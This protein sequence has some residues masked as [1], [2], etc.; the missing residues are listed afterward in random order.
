MSATA[1][2]DQLPSRAALRGARRVVIKV[3]TAMVA[4]SDGSPSLMRIGAMVEQIA[5]LIRSGKEVIFVSS[6]AVGM[7][8][9]L[10]RR[11]TRMTMSFTDL[12]HS[13]EHG[14]NGTNNN[15]LRDSHQMIIERRSIS[16]M[17]NKNNNKN[18][19]SFACLLEATKM[20]DKKSTEKQYDSACAAAGQLE[21]M[22]FYNSLFSQMELATSQILVTQAD[23]QDEL[24]LKNLTYAIDRLL[25]VGVIPIINE[26]D[27]VSANMGYTH[28]DT[29]S[30]NDSLA[31]LCARNF[32][33]EVLLLL[34][35]VQGVYD[36]PPSDEG[37]QLL[38]LYTDGADVAIG[39]KSTQGRGGMAAKINAAKSAVK[40]GSTCSACII[41]GGD[42]LDTI[43][44]VLY[45]VYDKKPPRG[46]LFATPDTDLHKQALLEFEAA[47]LASAT[48]VSDEARAM[49]TAA[50]NEA[51]KLQ[52]LPYTERQ[53]ILNA[54]AEA[55]ITNK[56]NLLKANAID[57]DAADKDGTALPLVKRLK[58]TDEKLA[59]L[60]SGIRQ[61]AQQKDPL[62]VVKSKRELA[63]GLELSQITVPIGVLMIIFESRPDSMPQISALALASGNGLLLKGGKEASRSNVALHKVIGEAIES[64]SGG[65][66]SKDI[67]GLVTSRG[68]VADMLN[69]DEVID[70]VIPRGSNALVSFIKANTK[71][72]VLGHADGVCHVYVAPSANSNAASKMVVDSKT[73]YPS[74][75]N[76]MESLLL[77]KDTIENGV[78][79]ATMMNLRAAGVKCFGGLNAMKYGLCDTVAKEL[80]FEYGDLR[81]LVEVVENVDE[82]IQWIHKY[83]SGHT[84]AIV[85][86]DED[87]EGEYFLK[88]VDAACVFK[89]ASTRFA[90]GYRFGLGAEVGISTGRIHARGPVGVEGLLTT[91]WQLRSKG[92]NYVAEFV[93]DTLESKEYTHR[94]LL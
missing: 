47:K 3:G 12:H 39:E 77:H 19:S 21:L 71:I 6:G 66:I 74:A 83:G 63:D 72:P 89:N 38:S 24:R 40:P 91:K 45:P 42:D 37:A 90:D 9:R 68:Q 35:D 79:M 60:A 15:N 1:N 87:P 29:F 13:Q 44:S 50:R 32:G 67:I 2:G 33:A 76:A 26:N 10:L 5:E 80:K 84:E 52:A 43:H 59:T 55:L 73:D 51:R 93:G 7:G 62:G 8:K 36:R 92:I 54:V 18:S 31:A 64:S 70:L 25:G 34:T 86:S 65:K 85:C 28:A 75:C 61:I 11:Q 27:A 20:K 4:S 41:A 81:C 82:A 17:D 14:E 48:S 78:A 16:R 57:L 30:D 46:T 58:L 49:A 23:F 94:E 53:A 56:E 69:L 22:R 88:L